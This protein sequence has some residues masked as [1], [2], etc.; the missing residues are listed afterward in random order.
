MF[1]IKLRT[2]M[3]YLSFKTNI[4]TTIMWLYFYFT[5]GGAPD[6]NVGLPGFEPAPTALLP[7]APTLEASPHLVCRC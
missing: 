1:K 5:K 7:D 2:N 4:L 6:D 3:I